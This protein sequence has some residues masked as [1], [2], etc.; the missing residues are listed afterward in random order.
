MSNQ[1]PPNPQQ[2][3]QPEQGPRF[4]VR[5]S[6][7]PGGY[8]WEAFDT[9]APQNTV[10]PPT[11]NRQT[12][13][14][15]ADQLNGLTK[16][17]RKHRTRNILLGVGAGLVVLIGAATLTADPA[18]EAPV[19]VTSQA[20]QPVPSVKPTKQAHSVP[21]KPAKTTQPAPA[22][23]PKPVVYKKLTARQWAKIAKSPDKYAG[24]AY[25]VYG[26]VTQFDSATGDD[27][28][29]ADVDGVKHA[30][31]YGFVDYPTNT[32]MTN[33]SGDVSDLVQDDL[34]SAK[35][36][37]MGSF[38]YDTQIGGET[39]VPQLSVMSITVTGSVK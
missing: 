24:E 29:R 16:P 7:H 19:S 32:L 11:P 21:P 23:K 5:P 18:A 31:E 33:I 15:K 6:A 36:L 4:Q 28:F 8:Y 35:V 3:L 22:P 34:F 9:L 20:T 30:V 14:A 17:P 39:T 2:P 10:M 1:Y 38:S 13:Q 12:A 25:V 27:Q 26:V 37:V